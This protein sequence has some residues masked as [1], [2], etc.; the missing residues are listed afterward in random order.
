MAK[1]QSLIRSARTGRFTSRAN[2]KRNPSTTV[3][4]TRAHK[5]SKKKRR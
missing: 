1:K 3:R 4:E 2:E 5:A